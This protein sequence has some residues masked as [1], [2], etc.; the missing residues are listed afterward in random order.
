MDRQYSIKHYWYSAMQIYA[1]PGYQQHMHHS[2]TN[3]YTCKSKALHTCITAVVGQQV[4]C[5]LSNQWAVLHTTLLTNLSVVAMEP[6]QERKVQAMLPSLRTSDLVIW[7]NLRRLRDSVTSPC[8][9][10]SLP[11]QTVSGDPILDTNSS[12]Y[13]RF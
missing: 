11:V 13:R 5:E 10:R 6:S 1:L 2:L 12:Y 4:G 8:V 7:T 9:H 3:M